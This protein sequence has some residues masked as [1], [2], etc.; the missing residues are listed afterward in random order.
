MATRFVGLA[1][2]AT[3]VLEARLP[4]AIGGSA[5]NE[6]VGSRSTIPVAAGVT[7][8]EAARDEALFLVLRHPVLCEHDSNAEVEGPNIS[9]SDGGRNRNS[10]RALLGLCIVLQQHTW[11]FHRAVTIVDVL[12]WYFV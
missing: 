9:S 7:G 5:L 4:C 2:I 6:D 11:M 12:I 3:T 10:L 8:D 1:I